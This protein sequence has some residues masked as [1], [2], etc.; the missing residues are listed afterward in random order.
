MNSK[1]QQKQRAILMGAQENK[2]T[3]SQELW[4]PRWNAENFMCKMSFCEI[5]HLFSR[6]TH[7]KFSLVLLQIANYIYG[8]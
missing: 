7:K 1:Q 5:W 3:I 4:K 2:C 6:G 8:S